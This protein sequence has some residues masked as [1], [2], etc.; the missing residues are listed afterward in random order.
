MWGTFEKRL[1]ITLAAI[2]WLCWMLIQAVWQMWG[3]WPKP[4]EFWGRPTSMPMYR[5]RHV[6]GPFAPLAGAS[7]KKVRDLG[8][9]FYPNPSLP[10][11]APPPV[12]TRQVELVF[13]GYYTTSQGETRAYVSAGGQ[14]VVGPVGT[15]VFA[16][17]SIVEIGPGTLVLTDAL[18]KKITLDFSVKKTVEV[19]L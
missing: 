18:G 12:V 5:A 7:F 3:Q 2:A 10:P 19:P 4:P 17:Y 8:N 13:Q 1:A 6:A 14:T 9:P 11:P 15:K 16:D